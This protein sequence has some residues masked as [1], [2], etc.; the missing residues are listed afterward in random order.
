[1]KAD[2]RKG[3]RIVNHCHRKLGA[4]GQ[5][6]QGRVGSTRTTRSRMISRGRRGPVAALDEVENPA[7]VPWIRQLDSFVENTLLFFSVALFLA[8][9][10]GVGGSLGC[11]Y[12]AWIISTIS[13]RCIWMIF[14]DLPL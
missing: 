8:G 14:A 5:G 11:R 4:L 10:R 7:P 1:M 9:D 12:Y 2:T 13:I 3:P 6:T